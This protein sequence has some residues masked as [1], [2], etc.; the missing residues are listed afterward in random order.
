MTYILCEMLIYY[1]SLS[2]MYVYGAVCFR[3]ILKASVYMIKRMKL[4]QDNGSLYIRGR[5]DDTWRS[6][7]HSRVRVPGV[8]APHMDGGWYYR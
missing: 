7:R 4:M 5:S 1:M 3:L 8:G 6:E 2:C